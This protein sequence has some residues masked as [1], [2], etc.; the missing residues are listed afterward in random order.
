MFTELYKELQMSYFV[1]L[2]SDTELKPVDW[3]W[4]LCMAVLFYKVSNAISRH[5]TTEMTRHVRN[6]KF[7]ILIL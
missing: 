5:Y 4:H 3:Y 6:N 2:T 7:Y 1:F